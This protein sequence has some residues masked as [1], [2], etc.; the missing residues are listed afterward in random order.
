[1][2]K[3]FGAREFGVFRVQNLEDPRGQDTSEVKWS[4]TRSASRE[5]WIF[6][7]TKSC[8]VMYTVILIEIWCLT[9]LVPRD[10][11]LL[12]FQNFAK[13]ELLSNLKCA[14]IIS[15]ISSLFSVRTK[16]ILFAK[17]KK[18][19][20]L[21]IQSSQLVHF[22]TFFLEYAEGCWQLFVFWLLF[23]DFLTE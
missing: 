15:V 8:I 17:W 5:G 20:G 16:C 1:M 23:E 3:L 9:I 21:V 2:K 19:F 22:P 10:N 4:G 11:Q 14:K 7:Q 13:L 12:K 18:K 6:R